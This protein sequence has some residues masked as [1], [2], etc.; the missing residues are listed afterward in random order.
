MKP[1][2]PKVCAAWLG[3]CLLCGCAEGGGDNAPAPVDVLVEGIAKQQ[4]LVN[5]EAFASAAGDLHDAATQFCDAP[6]DGDF[7]AVQ[8]AWQHG[9]EAWYRV[10]LFNFGPADVDPVLPAYSFIDSLR[11]RGTDYTDD[12]RN[13]LARWR[14]G[15]E[16]LDSAFFAEQRF[17]DLGLLAVELALYDSADLEAAYDGDARRCELLVGLTGDLRSR[18]ESLRAGWIESYDGGD[19][20]FLDLLLSAA[21]PNGRL[22]LVQVLVSAQEY[23][24]Y[25]HSR[26]VV[27]LAGQASGTTWDL[28]DAGVGAIE[29]LLTQDL[30][31]GSVFYWME[32]LDGPEP[33]QAV[34]EKLDATR[35]ALEAQDAD[36]LEATLAELDGC[37]KREVPDAL[38]VELGLNFTDGD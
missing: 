4:I 8:S 33:V 29:A 11:L 2:P 30:K 9:A 35:A 25:L 21:L 36:T 15:D 23:A 28:L 26:H 37:F 3:I 12:L 34:R 6:A 16:P 22:P 14:T 24:D 18:A 5:V 38:Q 31:G 19:T 1:L 7:S 27:K 17:N 20:G 13:A 10:Q 32:R